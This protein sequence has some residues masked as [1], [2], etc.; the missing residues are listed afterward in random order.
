MDVTHVGSQFEPLLGLVVR[1]DACR[2]TLVAR[3]VHDAVLVQIAHARIVGGLVRT[4]VHA[5]VVLL[6]QAVL[7][8]RV[9][10]V[11]GLHPIV[12]AVERHLAA[13]RGV[14]VELA[15]QPDQVLAVGTRVNVVGECLEHVRIGLCVGS[16]G[17]HALP[18]E[19]AVVVL[20]VHRLV[21]FARVGDDVV[22][23]HGARV[24]APLHVHVDHRVAGLRT[25]R[26]H[27]D[28][29]RCA[30]GSVQGG[31]SG[32]LEHG[33]R[34]DVG[35]RNVRQAGAVGRAVHDD[36]RVRVGVHRADA[37][38]VDRA[39]IGAGRA[40]AAAHLQTGH[41]TH[42]R[43]HHVGRLTLLEVFGLD[44]RSRSGECLFLGRTER[45]DEHVVDSRDILLELNIDRRLTGNGHFLRLVADERDVQVTV[46]PGLQ[47]ELACG[48]GRRTR[49]GSVH[50]D[51]S[52][53]DRVAVS[54]GNCTGNLL[55]LGH[56][57]EHS[58]PQY[59]N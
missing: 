8:G 58:P 30:A 42:Q 51:R 23:L 40:R 33:D 17:V 16:R 28:Y 15:V 12:R 34:F 10:P 6:A 19:V 52:T 21:V 57:K 48:V 20:C 50:H 22:I 26:R 24:H 54:I 59:S 39:R 49:R 56:R 53:D 35:L 27:D 7:V 29:A 45:Y 55:L 43:V 47:A 2:D 41:G 13:Q 44:D 14:G 46:A 3:I 9:G 1:L 36:E 25:L 32:V 4:A 37:A 18:V 38:D 11:V 31:R 5:H